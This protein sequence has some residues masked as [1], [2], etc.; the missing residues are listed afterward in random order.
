MIAIPI[1]E[2]SH[3]VAPNSASEGLDCFVKTM[4]VIKPVNEMS[5]T[6]L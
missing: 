3:E 1:R 4:P 6:D 2:G 5:A